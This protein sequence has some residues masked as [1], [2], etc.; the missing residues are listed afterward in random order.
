MTYTGYAVLFFA[1]LGLVVL[2]SLYVQV[3]AAMRLARV[4]RGR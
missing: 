1:G 3:R 2:W 4:L